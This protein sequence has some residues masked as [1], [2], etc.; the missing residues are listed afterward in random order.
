MSEC[1]R[2]SDSSGGMQKPQQPC[3]KA[4]AADPWPTR[5][6]YDALGLLD[7]NNKQTAQQYKDDG[8]KWLPLVYQ[9]FNK[10]TILEQPVD[11]TT[12][13]SKYTDFATQFVADHKDSPFFLY[14]PFS[15]V[16]TTASHTFDKQYAGCD[17]QNTSVRGHFGDALSELDDCDSDLHGLDLTSQAFHSVPVSTSSLDCGRSACLPGVSLA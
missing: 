17:F 12:L 2:D 8:T 14:V 10:T 15:H 9:E 11:L 4:S 5:G 6:M 13:A 1:A 3:T 16:H 7:A